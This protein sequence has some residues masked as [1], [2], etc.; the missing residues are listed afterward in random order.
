[1]LQ[2][3]DSNLSLSALTRR[4]LSRTFSRQHE[5]P[6]PFNTVPN[7]GAALSFPGLLFLICRQ[8]AGYRSPT[9]RI[10]WTPSALCSQLTV[11]LWFLREAMGL[12]GLWRLEFKPT[13]S[14]SGSITF[15]LMGSPT[16]I[17][18]WTSSSVH[19]RFSLSYG[20][21]ASGSLST[22]IRRPI[23]ISCQE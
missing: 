5:Y 1:M 6:G 18:H 3:S 13:S 23:P 14:V 11:E 8:F 10:L 21:T 15:R 16:L 22:P 12:S 19:Q 9:R 20:P 2:Q 4:K 17:T 7:A